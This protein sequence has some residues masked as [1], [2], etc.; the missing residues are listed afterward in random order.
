MIKRKEGITLIALVITIIVL[1]ILA[2]ITITLTLGDNGIIA[3][4]RK[5]SIVTRRASVIEKL[6]EY[7]IEKKISEATG[8]EYNPRKC[9][10]YN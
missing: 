7:K 8:K 2:G 4:A 5:A 1:L 6:N 10:R 9:R 3:K